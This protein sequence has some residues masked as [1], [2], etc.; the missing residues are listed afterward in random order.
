MVAIDLVSDFREIVEQ[1]LDVLGHPQSPNEDLDTVQHRYLNIVSRM[2]AAIQW[3]LQESEQIN[4]AQLQ[5]EIQTGYQHFKQAAAA[6]NDLKPYLSTRIGDPDFADLMF[7]DWGIYHFHLGTGIDDRGFINRTDELLFAVSDP[8]SSTM[9]LID[10]HPH[11]G[12]FSNQDLL[13]VLEE[14]WPNVVDRYT[15]NGVTG[16]SYN[17]SDEEIHELRKS[18]V[19]VMIQTPGGRVL[20]P[21]GGG[22]TTA[23]TSVQHRME[24]DR[25]IKEI[26]QYEKIVTDNRD[27]LSAFF[28]SRHGKSWDDLEFR[29]T[30]Y[31]QSIRVIETTTGEVVLQQNFV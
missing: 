11:S 12:A 7:Y 19:N 5:P 28:E 16:L 21:M 17:A 29:M 23:G 26:R 3:I 13:R 15:L 25:A 27:N 31:G 6:G 24:T 10:I 8:R 4:N 20:A 30:D 1:E 9:Y 22:I 2:P 18:G 14:N